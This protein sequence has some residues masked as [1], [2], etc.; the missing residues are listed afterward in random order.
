M[1][2]LKLNH[3]SKSGHR[4]H[5]KSPTLN[6]IFRILSNLYKSHMNSQHLNVSH[7][8]VVSTQSIEARCSVK[9]EDVV[10]AAQSI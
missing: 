9:N 3:V 6:M 2:G 4:K 7:L 8:L 10:G 5:N 1:L